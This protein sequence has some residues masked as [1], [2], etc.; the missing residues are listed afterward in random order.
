MEGGKLF[1]YVYQQCYQLS[2]FNSPDPFRCVLIRIYLIAKAACEV[3]SVPITQM[4]ELRFKV[5]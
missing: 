2:T 4:R 5:T 3:G 1:S